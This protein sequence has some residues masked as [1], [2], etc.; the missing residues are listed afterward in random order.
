MCSLPIKTNPY[1]RRWTN[2]TAPGGFTLVELLVVIGIIALLLAILLPALNSARARASDIRCAAHMKQVATALLE[3]ATN[4]RNQF[5]PNNTS[6]APGR[7]WYD[8]DRM[9]RYLSDSPPAGGGI[10]GGVLLCPADEIG[11]RS[12]TMNVWVGSELPPQA[13]KDIATN[14]PYDLAPGLRWK[15]G[16]KQADRVFLLLEA[17]GTAPTGLLPPPFVGA[18]G[19]PPVSPGRR[20]GGAG[21]CN[22]LINTIRFGLRNSEIAFP[23]HDSPGR[24]NEPLGG[25]ANFAFCDGHVEMLARGELIDS[26]G[27]STLRGLWSLQDSRINY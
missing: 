19:K 4:N 25:R 7:L 16:D 11:Y 18:P 3:Y 23:R 17:W 27:K 1:A 21:G 8:K 13:Y 20:F 15:P 12:Y 6:P 10:K 14:I 5:P 2:R 24:F 9:G 22:P 26:S